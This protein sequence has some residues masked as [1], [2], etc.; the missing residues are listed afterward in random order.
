MSRGPQV[1]DGVTIRIARGR[2]TAV[3]GPSAVSKTT[4]LRAFNRLEEPPA[5]RVL[6]E[7]RDVRDL[8][9]CRLRRRVAL[10]C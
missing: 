9:P 8:C 1:L 4:L 3:V 7:G 6:L 2:V 5:G 10:S